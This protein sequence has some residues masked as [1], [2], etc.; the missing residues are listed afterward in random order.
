MLTSL[1]TGAG[2]L[3]TG[4]V[5]VSVEPE[6]FLEQKDK[7]PATIAAIKHP[8][9]YVVLNFIRRWCVVQLLAIEA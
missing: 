4:G 8:Y 3:V 5:V 2:G 7:L 1:V 6:D 9:M